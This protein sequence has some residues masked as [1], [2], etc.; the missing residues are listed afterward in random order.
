MQTAVEGQIPRNC[1]SAAIPGGTIARS[2]R[3]KPFLPAYFSAV[4]VSNHAVRTPSSE[5]M[6]TARSCRGRGDALAA[7]VRDHRE[8]PEQTVLPDDLHGDAADHPPTSNRHD[9]LLA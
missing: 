8:R 4:V 3:A 7:P 9:E 1:G 2:A 6:A 5:A